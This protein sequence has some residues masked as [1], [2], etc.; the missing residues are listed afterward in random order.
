M[1][2][3][4]LVAVAFDAFIA[5]LAI[6]IYDETLLTNLQDVDQ[7]RE[8]AHGS[9]PIDAAGVRAQGL[10]E[11]LANPPMAGNPDTSQQC[12]GNS[13]IQGVRG[14]LHQRKQWRL[15]RFR[16]SLVHQLVHEEMC[17]KNTSKQDLCMLFENA[18]EDLTRRSSLG[19]KSYMG[20]NPGFQVSFEIRQAGYKGLGL[21]AMQKIPKGTLIYQ[22]EDYNF[23]FV[24]S[25]QAD[26]MKAIAAGYPD[27]VV[28]LLGGWCGRDWLCNHN[29]GIICSMGEDRYINH[30]DEPNVGCCKNSKSCRSMCALHDIPP[31]EELVED[32]YEENLDSMESLSMVRIIEEVAGSQV[33]LMESSSKCSQAR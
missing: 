19:S 3:R 15:R 31:A 10:Q 26:E 27:K 5:T 20:T 1:S 24:P 32:Y 8:E 30:S 13:L 14:A 4:V 12:S 2:G 9:R 25:H 33:G 28:N 23:L 22:D 11:A 6:N 29:G 18:Y 17:A 21:F 16:N 7:V